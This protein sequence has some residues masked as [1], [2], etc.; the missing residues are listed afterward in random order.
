[1][2]RA[3]AR[4]DAPMRVVADVVVAAGSSVHRFADWTHDGVGLL[5]V[6]AADADAVA[7]AMRVMGDVASAASGRDR[8]GH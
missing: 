6:D 3:R 1:M 8:R 4:P 2:I 5:R 7:S